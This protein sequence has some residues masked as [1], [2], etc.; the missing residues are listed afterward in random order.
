MGAEPSASEVSLLPAS[1]LAESLGAAATRVG[2]GRLSCRFAAA[3][4]C[5]GSQREFLVEDAQCQVG[6]PLEREVPSGDAVFV[7]RCRRYR[8]ERFRSGA[9]FFR[10]T[11]EL[12]N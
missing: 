12:L 5:R 6:C 10:P 2:R 7:K 9:P 3:G 8:S 11:G 4:P 1:P